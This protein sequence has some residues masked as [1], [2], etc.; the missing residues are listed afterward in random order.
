MGSRG[1]PAAAARAPTLPRRPPA[2]LAAPLLL[3]LF[4]LLLLAAGPPRGCFAAAADAAV[5]DA[6][7]ADADTFRVEAV[8]LTAEEQNEV[9]RRQ[10]EA[11]ANL[12]KASMDHNIPALADALLAGADVNGRDAAGNFPLLVVFQRKDALLTLRLLLAAGA[13]PEL[14]TIRGRAAGSS[15]HV[16]DNRQVHGSDGKIRKFPEGATVDEILSNA[17]A[18]NGP[19][20]ERAMPGEVR[21]EFKEAVRRLQLASLRTEA[22]RTADHTDAMKYLVEMDRF[23]KDVA[24]FHGTDKKTLNALPEEQQQELLRAYE[25]SEPYF[26]K[27]REKYGADWKPPKPQAADTTPPPAVTEKEEPSAP[28]ETDGDVDEVISL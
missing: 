24:A 15:G 23:R 3:L 19:D 2:C 4:L 12:I 18:G 22:Q 10:A 7:P 25:Q 16:R 6:A 9:L 28:V 5:A 17:L 20:Q 1:V 27:M 21:A 13:D 26:E 8:E 11:T 14:R